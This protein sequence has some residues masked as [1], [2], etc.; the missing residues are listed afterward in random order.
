MSGALTC[1][2]TCPDRATAHVSVVGEL[3]F[4]TAGMLLNLVTGWLADHPGVRDVRIDCGEIA[5]CDSSGL[6]ALLRV[7]RVVT[8]AGAR[9]HLDNRRRALDRLLT[10][11]GTAAY[12]TG[13]A[14]VSRARVDS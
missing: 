3:E 13:E 12:L 5:F 9:L 14:V 7:H 2:W 10:L 4:A 6:S 8:G 1:T 11:T